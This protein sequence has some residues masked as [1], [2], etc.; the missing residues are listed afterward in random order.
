MRKPTQIRVRALT[1]ITPQVAEIMV[2]RLGMDAII[3]AYKGDN[4][5]G[6]YDLI[7][8]ELPSAVTDSEVRD[9]ANILNERAR[10]A[11]FLM[12]ATISGATY[13]IYIGED[14]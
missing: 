14:D 3:K 10:E 9:I 1:S 4:Y 5:Q 12:P 7:R 13:S 2:K 8:P 11:N 6:I